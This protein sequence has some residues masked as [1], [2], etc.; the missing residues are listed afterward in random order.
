MSS[1]DKELPNFYKLLQDIDQ[2]LDILLS[3]GKLVLDP[4]NKTDSLWIDQ[5]EKMYPVGAERVYE[6]NLDSPAHCYYFTPE[7]RKAHTNG[8]VEEVDTSVHPLHENLY[9]G[10]ERL[11]RD[12]SY[13][14]I[15]NVGVFGAEP[16]FRNPEQ[17]KDFFQRADNLVLYSKGD[18]VSLSQLTKVLLSLIS[19][20]SILEGK[21]KTVFLDNSDSRFDPFLSLAGLD[22]SEGVD[23]LNTWFSQNRPNTHFGV[24]EE[25]GTIISHIKAMGID[26]ER[27]LPPTELLFQRA[28]LA[29]HSE[30]KEDDTARVI[31]R[32]RF[33]I[34]VAHSDT[35]CGHSETDPE[36][37][38]SLGGNAKAKLIATLEDKI[39]DP[40]LDATLASFELTRKTGFLCVFDGGEDVIDRALRDTEVLE[41]YLSA[42][43]PLC[44]FPGSETKPFSQKFGDIPERFHAF[45][46]AYDELGVSS[47]K[48]FVDNCVVLLASL[49]QVD[50]KKPVYYAFKSRALMEYIF[51]PRPDYHYHKT[52]RHFQKP[53]DRSET[54]AELEEN[55]DRWMTDELAISRAFGLACRAS[56]VKQI[57][58]SPSLQFDTVRSLKITSPVPLPLEL[59]AKAMHEGVNL[60]SSDKTPG[61]FDDIRR[62][63]RSGDGYCFV[64]TPVAKDENFWM[65]RIC[66]PASILVAKQLRDPVVNGHPFAFLRSPDG[67]KSD[68]QRIVD[69][70]KKCGMITHDLNR[71]LCDANDVT[72]M[73]KYLKSNAVQ[74]GFVRTDNIQYPY[75]ELPDTGQE[76]VTFLL[77]ASSANAQDM[78]DAFEAT[79][80]WGMNGYGLLSG[81]GAQF[82]MGWHVWAGLEM[83]RLG[84]DV[85]VQGVQDPYAMKTEGWPIQEMNKLMGE[86]HAVM[87]PDILVRVEQLAELRRLQYYQGSKKIFV[88]QANGA[89]GLQEISGLLALR[90][91]GVEALQDAHFIIQNRPR[92]MITGEVLRVHDVLIDTIFARGSGKNVHVCETVEEM[93]KIGSKITGR[94]LDYHDVKRPV[95]TDYPFEP[96]KNPLY[97]WLMDPHTKENIVLPDFSREPT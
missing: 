33:N 64:N 92:T 46:K 72:S 1:Y 79:V 39:A 56:G 28:F 43:H 2:R 19:D 75:R 18:L 93:M 58:P 82:P 94:K 84:H 16:H 44:E 42:T 60:N 63:M 77:S 87:A 37:K 17:Y 36:F 30:E 52:Q 49:S 41:P 74:T 31:K 97:R 71:L 96:V 78:D 88:N 32:R 73:V 51:Q 15:N 38:W 40:N 80:N 89:G 5:L 55:Q 90:D 9:I 81:M 67:Q 3:G 95:Q 6:R 48:R 25:K 21:P 27:K 69:H 22:Y 91:A 83:R 76:M 26:L 24:V 35:L 29:T 14:G 53:L 50:P 54:I 85:D 34:K 62:Y 86:G 45:S 61:S 20:D 23:W 8:L 66:T 10:H 4:D 13:S 47:D 57:P 11:L 65:S 70:L 7:Q 59:K 68:F 12:S